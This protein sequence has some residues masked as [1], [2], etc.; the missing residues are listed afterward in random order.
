MSKVG[1]NPLIL[2]DLKRLWQYFRLLGMKEVWLAISKTGVR[3]IVGYSL[4]IIIALLLAIIAQ[5]KSFGKVIMPSISFFR[6][7]PT[8]S[9]MVIILLWFQQHQAMFII[10]FLIV[11][12][13]LFEVFYQ[14]IQHV[15]PH[16]LEVATVYRFSWI[17]KIKM[18]YYYQMIE[19]FFMSVKQTLGLAFKVMVM[20]EVIGQA[21]VGIGAKINHARIN[22]EMEGIMI[23]TI[24]LIVMVLLLEF[25]LTKLVNKLLKWR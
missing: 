5:I 8:I 17:K 12:P 6:S 7:I 11:F 14:G 18:I 16:L 9:V 13:I 20:A 19:D 23:W 24:I 25:I 15:D 2:P 4:S 10:G 3:T 22:L 21:R 1:N